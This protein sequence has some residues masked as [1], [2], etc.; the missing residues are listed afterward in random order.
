MADTT[1]TI[2]Y[3]KNTLLSQWV[4]QVRAR[5]TIGA[6]VDCAVCD[7]LINDV[8]DAFDINI[9]VGPQLDILGEYIG[10]SRTVYGQIIR[11]YFNLDD[12]GFYATIDD[13]AFDTLTD[14]PNGET[15]IGTGTGSREY[16][17]I[18][19]TS[20]PKRV[21]RVI[22][23]VK[24]QVSSTG[25]LSCRI[26]SGSSVHSMVLEQAATAVVDVTT[27][28]PGEWNSVQFDFAEVFA[29]SSQFFVVF[30][31]SSSSNGIAYANRTGTLGDE[32]SSW[33][34]DSWAGGNPGSAIAI[35]AS[36]YEQT[37]TP[38]YEINGMTDYIDGSVNPGSVTYRYSFDSEAVYTLEDDEYRFMLNLKRELNAL[39]NTLYEIQNVLWNFLGDDIRL[40][41]LRD[42]TIS[43]YIKP[44]AGRFAQLAAS[45]G[46]LPKPMGVALSG[47]FQVPD[48]SKV[49]GFQ[50]YVVPN[51][52]TIGFG[53]Y[54]TGFNDRYWLDYT[55]KL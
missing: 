47:V 7:L 9:A 20:S 30:A 55:N 32:S 2:E 4:N 15:T 50:D 27:L 34:N 35:R 3:Y 54:V 8:R 42:M 29:T 18:K 25:T 45:Q 37:T 44:T 40:F 23:S 43:Y 6:L 11:P 21:N 46:L 10:F 33:T 13:E 53:D 16:A 1:A 22:V 12:Y 38:P 39:D 51:N 19:N 36:E 17:F 49:M 14:T 28:I 26:M 24:P 48:P 52:N 5:G 31:E 41:D